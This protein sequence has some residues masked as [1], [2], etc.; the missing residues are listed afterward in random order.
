MAKSKN[1]KPSD[2]ALVLKGHTSTV[3]DV[4]VTPDGTRAVSASEDQT[5]RGCDFFGEPLY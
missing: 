3:W 2:T 1:Q 5:L 4:A